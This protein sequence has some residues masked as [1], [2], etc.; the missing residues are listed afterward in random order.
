MSSKRAALAVAEGVSRL[1]RVLPA[2]LRENF[3]FGLFVLESRGDSAEG[4][5]RLFALQDRLEL[6][7][8]ERAMAF[9]RG[10]HPKHRLTRYHDYFIGRIDDGERV[11]DVGC[12][13]GAVARSIARAK[14]A[15]KVMGVDYDDGRLAQAR[16]GDNPTNLSFSES[17]ATKTVPDGPWDVV[18]LSNVLEHIKDRVGLLKALQETTKAKRFLIRVPLFERDWKLAMRR[19]LGVNY[20]SDPDH[21]IEPRQSEFRDEMA[22]AGLTVD[23]LITPWGEIWATMSVANR[24]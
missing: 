22:Q 16:A 23:E 4:L 10:E 13:Y 21:K 8:N 11:L 15:S 6:A 24:V 5:R 3:I 12:G 18:V 14:P 20:Y 19:E 1:W 7:V 17:D 9:G 2:R